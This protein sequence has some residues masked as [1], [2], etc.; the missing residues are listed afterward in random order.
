MAV[1][2]AQRQ[3]VRGL[4]QRKWRRK[5]SA[6]AV[7]GLVNVGELLASPLAV[8][9]VYATAPALE[10]F[11]QNPV[12]REALAGIEVQ[13]VSPAELARLSTQRSP[14]GAVAV[15]RTA[16]SDP[17]VLAQAGRVLYLDGVA[18]PG[19]VGTLVRT[20]EWFGVDCVAAGP[21]TADFYN[22][23]VVAAARGSL[24]RVPHIALAAEHIARLRGDPPTR[25][26]LVADLD[27]TPYADA[28]WPERGV[29]AIGSESHGPT[30]LLRGL[31]PKPVTIARAGR[32]PTESL[33]A[34]VAGGILLA[35]WAGGVRAAD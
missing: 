14:H 26:I 23:K 15:A 3:R 7:E 13:Q 22:P 21:N 35:A 16:A 19:N 1:T 33:N 31:S 6:F 29:L 11:R 18:D 25:E 30:P 5:Y 28:S 32:A 2:Q 9:E 4:A 24:F 12:Y 27:G 10:G 20:A 8:L 34:A 17:E